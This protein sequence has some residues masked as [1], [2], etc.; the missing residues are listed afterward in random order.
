M[1]VPFCL[2]KRS[3][4]GSVGCDVRVMSP[5]GRM[6]RSR[7]IGTVEKVVCVGCQP[8]N[9]S[10]TWGGVSRGLFFDECLRL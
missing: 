3:S 7:F 2:C 8:P 10:A 9:V 5:V 6:S 1:R 4:E